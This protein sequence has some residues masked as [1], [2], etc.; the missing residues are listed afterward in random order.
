MMKKSVEDLYKELE[1]KSKNKYI[2]KED[3]IKTLEDFMIRKED[4]QREVACQVSTFT[5]R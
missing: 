2:K 4:T 1:N 5:V 3:L